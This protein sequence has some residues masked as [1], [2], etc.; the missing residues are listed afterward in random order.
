MGFLIVLELSAGFI[1]KVAFPVCAG[2][3]SFF[4]SV[5]SNRPTEKLCMF[6][7]YIIKHGHTRRLTN[8][9]S[10]KPTLYI[11]L[12]PIYFIPFQSRVHD[13]NR[14]QK[15][16]SWNDMSHEGGSILESFAVGT[17]LVIFWFRYKVM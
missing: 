11:E 7:V 6:G 12:N 16:C 8:V 14:K 4:H 15:S 13:K 2:A 3:R 9:L 5:F 10:L 17:E 1:K